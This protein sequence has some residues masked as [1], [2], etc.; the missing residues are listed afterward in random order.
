MMDHLRIAM[1]LAD[2]KVN[3]PDAVKLMYQAYLKSE[4]E[5]CATCNKRDDCPVYDAIKVDEP[6]L[7]LPE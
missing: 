5:D 4:G 3:A 1:V 7:R 6:S 2:I